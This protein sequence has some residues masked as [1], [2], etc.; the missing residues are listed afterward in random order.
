MLGIF[1]SQ[2]GGQRRSVAT[3]EGR[4][5]SNRILKR[6]VEQQEAGGRKDGKQPKHVFCEICCGLVQCTH[7]AGN[8]GE[9]KRVNMQVR[10]FIGKHT[11]VGRPFIMQCSL[12]ACII[13]QRVLE[14]RRDYGVP[15]QPVFVTNI[16]VHC[17][18]PDETIA[19]WMRI[20]TR[21][22]GVLEVA[23]LLPER[24]RNFAAK[25]LN[26]VSVLRLMQ[27]HPIMP[28]SPLPGMPMQHAA[29]C[30]WHLYGRLRSMDCVSWVGLF[31][32]RYGRV[33]FTDSTTMLGD[34]HE[35]TA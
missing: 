2:G 25:S 14:K 4:A 5:A 3:A 6:T 9:A 13:A 1:A 21:H 19:G 29:V 17:S 31:F 33:P 22:V 32:H 28:L 30:N 11:S 23:G 12:G 27:L 18:V 15:G 10:S 26:V 34:I 24:V 7:R 35:F 20:L 16:R 8:P